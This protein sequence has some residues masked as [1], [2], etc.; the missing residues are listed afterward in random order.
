M[1]SIILKTAST[2]LTLLIIYCIVSFFQSCKKENIQLDQ[3]SHLLLLKNSQEEGRFMEKE[4]PEGKHT[5]LLAKIEADQHFNIKTKEQLL[6]FGADPLNRE[7]LAARLNL[8][9]SLLTQVIEEIDLMR[10]GLDVVT[11]QIIQNIR[12]RGQDIH[13]DGL[14]DIAAFQDANK[15]ES[16][17]NRE[18]ITKYIEASP[19]GFEYEIPTEAFLESA[20]QMAQ[21]IQPVI[22]YNSSENLK[23][24]Q[25][26]GRFEQKETKEGKHAVLLAQLQQQDKF[27]INTKEDLL[28]FGAIPS[29]R[30][31]L[32]DFLNIHPSLLTQII[33][34]VDLMRCGLDVITIQIMQ[35]IHYKEQ[36][37]HMDGLIDIAAYS[38]DTEQFESK[39]QAVKI[40]KYIQSFPLDFDYVVPHE[41]F[42]ETA[43]RMAQSIQPMIIYE[44][45]KPLKVDK[46]YGEFEHAAFQHYNHIV[47]LDQ[48]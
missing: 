18:Q 12:Y 10:S 9:P 23:W 30:E 42:F 39:E 4:N 26:E 43:Y 7:S 33:E 28:E 40:K 22:I 46:L 25:D 36:D 41:M 16:K 5:M 1:K 48:V 14:F 21:N 29:N 20:Y 35:N 27:S 8:T 15:F 11:I 24:N 45:S 31:K 2:M 34:E 17:E 32:A 47:I 3:N 44:S 37:I 38:S 13:V 19:L 6:N